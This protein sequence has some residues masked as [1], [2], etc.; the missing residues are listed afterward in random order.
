MFE[1]IIY[2]VTMMND[3]MARVP[4]LPRLLK[5][6]WAKGCPRP[7]PIRPSRSLPMQNARVTF[8]AVSQRL[9]YVM[10]YQN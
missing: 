2:C 3:H 1:P 6:I 10:S 7:L 5:K 4:V 8:T 9:D